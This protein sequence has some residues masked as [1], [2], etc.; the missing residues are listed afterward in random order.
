MTGRL[1]APL[2]SGIVSFGIFG[3]LTLAIA[4]EGLKWI[5]FLAGTLTG[6][7]AFFVVHRA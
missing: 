6:G 7:V 1:F 3:G 4:P 5:A 2:F